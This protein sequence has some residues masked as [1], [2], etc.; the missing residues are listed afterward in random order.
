MLLPDCYVTYSLTNVY[1]QKPKLSHSTILLNHRVHVLYYMQ[2][3]MRGDSNISS[4]RDNFNVS[5]KTGFKDTAS[6][7]RSYRLITRAISPVEA[8]LYNGKNVLI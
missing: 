6:A 5:S 3:Y 4:I 2:V 1:V 8:S 7:S